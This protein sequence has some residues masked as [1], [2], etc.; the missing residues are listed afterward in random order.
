VTM[1]PKLYIDLTGLCGRKWTGVEQFAYLFSKTAA[2]K[3]NGFEVINIVLEEGKENLDIPDTDFFV[4]GKKRNRLLLNYILFP[5]FLLTKRPECV[6][7]PVFTPAKICFLVKNRST[8][9]I[10]LIHDTVPWN[11]SHTLSFWGKLLKGRCDTA[12]RKSYKVLTVSKTEMAAI[13]SICPAAR[14]D[15]VYNCIPDAVL[16][17]DTG[18]LQKLSLAP[19]KYILSVSTLEPRK[20]FAYTLRALEAILAADG[21][22]KVVLTGRQGWDQEIVKTVHNHRDK[23][24]RTGFVDTQDLST[25]YRNALF[26]ITLPIHEG[27]GRTPIEA[28]LNGTP[29]V[30]SDI[31]VFHELLNSGAFYLTLGNSVAAGDILKNNISGI[32]SSA[33]DTAYYQK[34]REE[35]YAALLP[36]NLFD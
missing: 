29:V 2:R 9:I 10:T 8:K 14:V 32:T 13:K 30:V 25:L 7:F 23:I 34:F 18:I 36:D 11:F 16:R 26:Y 17:G 1:K 15:C 12:L 24:V 6:I 3:F 20:N 21:E 35:N 4:I 5:W 33:I 22:L 19:G 27:F 28:R 31:P